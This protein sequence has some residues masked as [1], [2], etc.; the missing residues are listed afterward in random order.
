MVG[1]EFLPGRMKNIDIV[2]GKKTNQLRLGVNTGG[3]HN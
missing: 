3:T 2:S 1:D